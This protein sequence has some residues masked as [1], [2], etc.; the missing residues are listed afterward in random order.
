[1]F[2]R[3]ALLNHS[4]APNCVLAFD[5]SA[6]RVRTLRA[7]KATEELC[8]SYVPVGSS[9]AV[10]QAKLSSTHGFVC[11]CERCCDPSFAALDATLESQ[12]AAAAAGGS[13]GQDV[14]AWPSLES[15]RASLRLLEGALAHVPHHPTTSLQEYRLSELES[16]LGEPA[17]AL[18]L[19]ERCAHSL[20][21]S[22]GPDHPLS[23]DAARW[24]D[25]LRECVA[26]S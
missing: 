15:A 12:E 16:E 24:R 2:P 13:G 25:E 23:R 1:M 10:R 21:V 11:A 5:G 26:L 19:A 17:V 22:H 14:D 7:V 18:H 6:V 20:L 3:A 4:C 8:H 9:T